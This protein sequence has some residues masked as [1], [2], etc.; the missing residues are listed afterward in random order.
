[1]ARSRLAPRAYLEAGFQGRPRVFWQEPKP[2]WSNA[3]GLR[4]TGLEV[5]CEEQE[6]AQLDLN[7]LAGNASHTL[8]IQVQ[9]LE[10]PV[11]R[12]LAR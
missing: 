4:Q 5:F 10:D 9:R 3:A 6:R 7:N 12:D 1:M 11:S 8:R 2:H